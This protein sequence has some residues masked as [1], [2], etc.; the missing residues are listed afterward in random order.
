M[1]TQ[2][3][4]DRDMKLTVACADSLNPLL[5][6]ISAP[7]SPDDKPRNATNEKEHQELNCWIA[8]YVMGWKMHD[9]T[10]HPI[11][12]REMLA[13][14]WWISPDKIAA[15]A[16]CPKF[17]TDPAAAMEVLKKCAEKSNEIDPSSFVATG[18]FYKVFLV[19]MIYHDGETAKYLHESQAETPELAIC[20]FARKLFKK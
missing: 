11:K 18:V 3:E 5:E 20:L 17:T 1:N 10:L 8:E 9:F 2:L 7:A 16:D 6:S 12:G 4:A 19:I 15:S 14:I 13:G